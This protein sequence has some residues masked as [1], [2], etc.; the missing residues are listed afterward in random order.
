MHL[1]EYVNINLPLNQQHCTIHVY[2]LVPGI[3]VHWNGI[4]HACED[5]LSTKRLA[6]SSLR[7]AC[8]CNQP[9][10]EQHVYASALRATSNSMQN[11]LQSSLGE[12]TAYDRIKSYI[13]RSFAFNVNRKEFHIQIRRIFPPLW[14]R[15]HWTCRSTGRLLS[16]SYYGW[17]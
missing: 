1:N 2:V 14:S 5:A 9:G 16:Q 11:A 3:S 13:K 12:A 7:T 15:Q 17:R 6:S 8:I 10:S 4:L